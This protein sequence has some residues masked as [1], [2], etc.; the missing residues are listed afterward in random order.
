VI[1]SEEPPSEADFAERALTAATSAYAAS[2]SAWELGVRAAIGALF[3][4]LAADPRRT[5]A[6]IVD[7]LDGGPAGPPRR[8][9]LIRRFTALLQPGFDRSRVRPPEVVAEAIGG[10]IYEIV[11]AHAHQRRLGE[12]PAAVPEATVVAL[13]PF[14]G[15]DAA[16][17]LASSTKVQIDD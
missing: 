12:L 1:A 11:R 3:E 16:A 17:A 10:G 14:L 6:C 13:S 15:P 9:R 5:T 8:D 4:V 7:D 2:A